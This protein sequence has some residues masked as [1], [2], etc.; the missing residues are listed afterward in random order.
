MTEP[1]ERREAAW[2]AP[3][4]GVSDS[5]RGSDDASPTHKTVTLT[6]RIHY[7]H[8]CETLPKCQSKTW[9]AFT[10]LRA[11][12]KTSSEMTGGGTLRRKVFTHQV[13]LLLITLS[14][15]S[16]RSPFMQRPT[17]TQLKRADLGATL[18]ELTTERRSF[19]HAPKGNGRDVTR[20]PPTESII[21]SSGSRV[22]IWE[23][24]LGKMRDGNFSF[25]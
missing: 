16:P 5:A 8:S 4:W 6:S 21:H 7:A 3:R 15:R 1:K 25:N 19:K 18:L 24:A 11:S 12:L 9:A 23:G 14:H 13:Q 10:H 17:R 20:A 2:A 22:G